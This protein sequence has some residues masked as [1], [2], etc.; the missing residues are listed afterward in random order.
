MFF[1]SDLNFAKGLADL[2]TCCVKG[3]SNQ[4]RLNKNA[5]C[6]KV[7]REEIKFLKKKIK[8]YIRAK[9]QLLKKGS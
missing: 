8:S 5:S 7:R 1:T 2:M 4:S 3:W 6:K 9:P